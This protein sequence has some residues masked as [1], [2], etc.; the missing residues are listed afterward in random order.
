[1]LDHALRLL[2]AGVSVIPLNPRPEPDPDG[3]AKKPALASW[4]PYQS[5]LATEDEARQWWNMRS[6]RGMAVVTGAVSGVVV[7][8]LDGVEAVAWGHEHLPVTPARVRTHRGEHWYYAHPGTKTDNG[9]DVLKTKKAKGWAVDIRGD[10]GYVVAPP[11]VHP[12]GS[13][14]QWLQEPSG[15]WTAALPRFQSDWFKASERSTDLLLG[16]M[17]MNSQ[18]GRTTHQDADGS[19]RSN[20]APKIRSVIG[21]VLGTPE[22]PSAS[23]GITLPDSFDREVTART[24]GSAAVARDPMSPVERARRWMATHEPAVAGQG[25]NNRTYNA[26]CQL[27]RNFGLNEHDAFEV[28]AEW[29]RSCVPPWDDKDLR[30]FVRN[31]SKYGRGAVGAMIIEGPWEGSKRGV[32]RQGSD[33][34]GES[35]AEQPPKPVIRVVMAELERMVDEAEAALCLDPDV[36][37]RG[38]QLVQVRRDGARRI[39]MLERQPGEPVISA[40][41]TSRLLELMARSA[42]WVKRERRDGEWVE[43]PVAPPERVARALLERPEWAVRP[44]EGVIEAPTI[45]QDGTLLDQPGYDEAT[46]LLYLAESAPMVAVPEH[47]TQADAE[48]ALAFL[49]EELTPDFPWAEECHRSAALALLLT[50]LLRPLVPEQVPMFLITSSTPGSGKGLWIDVVAT[51]AF[52]RMA[53]TLVPREKD[54]QNHTAI[55]SLAMTGARLIK[56]DE[57]D[58]IDGAAL[59]SALTT[60]YW[61]DRRFHSQ[62]MVGIPVRWIWAATGVNPQI[63]GDMERRIVPIR[64][65]P[66]DARPDA[67]TDFRH[68]PLVPW[69]AAHRD[70]LLTACLTIGRAWVLAGRPQTECEPYG[71]YSAWSK[72]IRAMLLW[73]G[74]VD[75]NL[76]RQAVRD[77][78]AQARGPIEGLLAAW[79]ERWGTAPTKLAQA[80]REARQE[81]GDLWE[82]MLA[83]AGTRTGDDV[84]KVRLSLALRKVVRRILGGFAITSHLDRKG[85]SE[86]TVQPVVPGVPGVAGGSSYS[87]GQREEVAKKDLVEERSVQ[88]PPQPPAPPAPSGGPSA[89]VTA[90]AIDAAARWLRLAGAMS[91]ASL[92]VLCDDLLPVHVW[93]WHPA[94]LVAEHRDAL[95]WLRQLTPAQRVR[96]VDLAATQLGATTTVAICDSNEV[97][98]FELRPGA[99]SE[100]AG[101]LDEV[102]DEAWML[103]GWSAPKSVRGGVT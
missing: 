63:K 47:P 88:H 40:I 53:P 77:S 7:V 60:S 46:G 15:Q 4:E 82:M 23:A 84:D 76:G 93:A 37:Q 3:R 20:Q 2:A 67:R 35:D 91:A 65:E 80:I 50:T 34:A 5:A 90:D 36:F 44:I 52:G 1:M 89:A 94:T 61:Q 79:H 73:L 57:V 18:D 13:T 86:W 81:N 85:V 98:F 72:T 70:E 22:N 58:S 32:G 96:A 103:A 64:I 102:T 26:A 97:Q 78:A 10:G 21:R 30:R 99:A 17:S 41:G 95:G 101:W 6:R 83:I 33:A 45:R 14:Y 75:P 48:R 43:T 56:Y 92:V 100:W 42:R 62:E 38:G 39:K 27:A 28:L 71:S 29:N 74:A 69:V 59:R 16:T 12:N 8:D 31:A 11:T 19:A 87:T 54:D 9:A 68:D 24:A 66:E 25:G 49:R 51:V 55:T